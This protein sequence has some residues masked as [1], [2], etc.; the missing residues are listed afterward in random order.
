MKVWLGGIRREESRLL[1]S[2]AKSERI[3]TA[4]IR[5]HLFCDA[6]HGTFCGYERL[7]KAYEACD[8]LVKVMSRV[9]EAISIIL[10]VSLIPAL[11]A[12]SLFFVL[13]F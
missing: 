8:P 13:N 1:S 2:R 10:M 4:L 9:A 6:H 5:I 7:V 12:A 11:M 3:V